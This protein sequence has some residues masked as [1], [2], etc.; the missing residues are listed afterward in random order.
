M[1]VTIRHYYSLDEACLARSVL[2][3]AGMLALVHDEFMASSQWQLLSAIGGIRLQVEAVCAADALQLLKV[4]P[5]E[6]EPSIEVSLRESQVE[7][8]ARAAL[9]GCFFPY[10][11]FLTAWRL[12]RVATQPG[13]L[14]PLVKKRLW[15]ILIAQCVFLPIAA[16]EAATWIWA[17]F[18]PRI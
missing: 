6:S 13:T 11:A 14:R 7:S 1:L 9:V 5:D 8:V 12:G 16:A 15:I 18:G 10:A 17:M 4:S 3:D 2:E